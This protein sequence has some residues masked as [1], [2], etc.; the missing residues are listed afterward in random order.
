MLLRPKR[1]GRLNVSGIDYRS[2]APALTVIH[3][4]LGDTVI[5][6][7]I[8]GIRTPV[9]AYYQCGESPYQSKPK[10]LKLKV[11]ASS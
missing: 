9:R 11:T 4:C 8:A 7:G 5:P 1:L 6:A 10:A 2:H 3:K